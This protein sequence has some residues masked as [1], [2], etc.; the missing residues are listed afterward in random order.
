M[1]FW[2]FYMILL[3][4]VM[5]V[6][7]AIAIANVILAGFVTVVMLCSVYA[8]TGNSKYEKG[9]WATVRVA[10]IGARYGGKIGKNE[11]KSSASEDEIEDDIS[12]EEEEG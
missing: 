2:F 6:V 11:D 7:P 4:S 9:L 10:E 3:E 12:D 1:I 8:Y 5:A